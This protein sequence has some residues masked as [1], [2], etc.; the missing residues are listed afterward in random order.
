[1]P[2]FLYRDEDIRHGEWSTRRISRSPSLDVTS[3]E[4]EAEDD[5]VRKFGLRTLRRALKRRARA[6]TVEPD[7]TS[8]SVIVACEK[9]G[10]DYRIERIDFGQGRIGAFWMCA[11]GS[12][13]IPPG[14]AESFSLLRP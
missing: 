14:G 2:F 10:F 6:S 4:P 9:C 8:P 3:A 5:R 12:R 7:Q 13:Y 1:M 11:C